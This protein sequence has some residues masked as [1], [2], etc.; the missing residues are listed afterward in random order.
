MR[1]ME[2]MVRAGRGYMHGRWS[3]IAW[4]CGCSFEG[5]NS[6]VGDMGLG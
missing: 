6:Q 5:R 2:A 3:C 1:A 4:E